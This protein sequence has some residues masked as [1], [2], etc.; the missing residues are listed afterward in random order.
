MDDRVVFEDVRC[1]VHK[2]ETITACEPPTDNK[3][4]LASPLG[5]SMMQKYLVLY[6]NALLKSFV[7]TTTTP[8]RYT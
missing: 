7:D 6:T 1:G 5:T 3:H 2:H 4:R 8:A